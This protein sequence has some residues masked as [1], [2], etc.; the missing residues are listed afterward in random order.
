MAE[1]LGISQ[2][3]YSYME[4]GEKSNLTIDHLESLIEYF[5]VNPFYLLDGSGPMFVK[6]DKELD[7]LGA[8]MINAE[9][10]A[11]DSCLLV[12]VKAQAGYA[13]D[14]EGM[15]ISGD[16]YKVVLP[17]LN[18]GSARVF[19]IEGESMSPIVQDGDY[20]ACTKIEHLND[21]RN[22]LL[23]V[24]ITEFNGLVIKFLQVN[25]SQN[26]MKC[27]SYN[28]ERFKPFDLLL[29][30]VR[31]IWEVQLRVTKHFL[32]DHLST[33]HIGRGS[34][35]SRLEKFINSLDEQGAFEP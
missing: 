7:R 11:S 15:T 31:E 12:P 22:G 23:Y 4:K 3:A 34:S 33:S 32:T 5:D 6:N 18:G 10:F 13:D 20:V 25:V 29:E 28:Q 1:V 19:E 17:G 14:P 24:V 8:P 16:L 2:S 35:F 26:R 30:E 27:L 21:V 9:D